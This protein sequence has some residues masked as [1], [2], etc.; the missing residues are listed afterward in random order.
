MSHSGFT[1][2]IVEEAALEWLEGI[3]YAVLNGPAIAAGEP[4][5][6]RSDPSYRD[7]ILKGRL[8][9]ALLRLNP[10]LPREALEEAYNK[11][12]RIDAASLIERNHVSHRLMIDGVTVEYPRPDGSIAG[13]QARVIDFD[14][15]EQNDWVA[16][17]PVARMW[18][19]L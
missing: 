9:Q 2:S 16:V 4:A 5:A 11:L 13:A 1:E 8:V 10:G 17:N 12:T 19:C 14:S 6:E 15:T 7:V 18:C 3:G